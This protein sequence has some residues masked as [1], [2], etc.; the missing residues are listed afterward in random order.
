MKTQC[1][2]SVYTKCDTSVSVYSML[3]ICKCIQNLEHLEVYTPCGTS[4]NVYSMWDIHKCILRG[5][6][7]ECTLHVE[8][9]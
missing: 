9:L 8:H 6:I 2:R 3:V 4:V 1:N 5:N 7:C